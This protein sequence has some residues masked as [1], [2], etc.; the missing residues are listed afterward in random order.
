[1]GSIAVR[2]ERKHARLLYSIGS[3]AEDSVAACGA[4]KEL[5]D[6]WKVAI[7]GLT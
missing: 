4:S 5:Q 3:K 6:C 1:V 7:E 2:A